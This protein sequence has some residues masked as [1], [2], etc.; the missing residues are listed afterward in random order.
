MD[1]GAPTI[2]FSMPQRPSP[3]N[4]PPQNW[5]KPGSSGGS[6]PSRRRCASSTSRVEN[7]SSTAMRF[8]PAGL[9]AA[10]GL[11][12]KDA[13]AAASEEDPMNPLIN[14]RRSIFMPFSSRSV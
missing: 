11:G 10:A 8:T 12:M 3:S 9:A 13:F 14:V 5:V 7:S 1:P 6:C 4:I 2:S